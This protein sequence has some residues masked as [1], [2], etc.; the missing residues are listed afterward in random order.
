[1]PAIVG[2]TALSEIRAE[3][4]TPFEKL[5]LPDKVMVQL[6][7]GTQQGIPVEWNPDGYDSQKEGKQT[8]T[9]TLVIGESLMNPENYTASIQVQ[10]GMT[11]DEYL[12]Q[13]IE[14][15]QNL[16]EKDYTAESWK[17]FQEKLET[18]LALKENPEA[19]EEEKKDAAEKLEKAIEK[20][21]P[22]ADKE[23][24]K[25]AVEEAKKK[26]KEDYTEESWKTF[27]EALNKAEDIYGNP[28]AIQQDVD[29]ALEMLQKAME[30]LKESVDTKPLKKLIAEAEVEDAEQYTEDSWNRMMIALNEARAVLVDPE[31]NQEA[32]NQAYQKLKD[33]LDGLVEQAESET[34]DASALKESIKK[35][36]GLDRTAYTEDSW[37]VVQSALDAAREV[38]KDSKATQ[39][40]YDKAQKALEDAMTALQLLS[41]GNG[42]MTDDSVGDGTSNSPGAGN[43]GSQQSA[44]QTGDWTT[45]GR[46]LFLIGTS[47]GLMCLG[48]GFYIKKKRR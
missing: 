4:G 27:E 1:M 17:E 35:A 30:A 8:L 44:V 18:A 40:D 3:L 15:A 47:I 5:E 36:E 41:G 2:V 10:V 29:V 6:T 28:N 16:Q 33:A 38:L 12:N 37:S 11:V 31:M 21:I 42:N 43:Q 26:Q 25:K 7:D 13:A 32:V 20:L 24:L 23:M 45:F 19:T 39:T 22:T 46:Y 14:K 9:G 34:P 48:L